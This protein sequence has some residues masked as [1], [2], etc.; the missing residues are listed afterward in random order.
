[1]PLKPAI[2]SNEQFLH[3]L[4]GL[5]GLGWTASM[6]GFLGSLIWYGNDVRPALP[7]G[8]RTL[9]GLGICFFLATQLLD[10]LR[11]A[12]ADRAE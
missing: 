3:E 2:L 11:M 12:G 9:L 5:T 6:L 4:A 10:R 7:I 8:P 1:M